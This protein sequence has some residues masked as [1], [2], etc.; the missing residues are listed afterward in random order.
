MSDHKPAV[1]AVSYGAPTKTIEPRFDARVS[2]QEFGPHRPNATYTW[3]VE[4]AGVRYT[5][6]G[7]RLIEEGDDL[8]FSSAQCETVRIEDMAIGDEKVSHE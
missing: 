8:I 6:S 5:F 2:K 1:D 4:R 7:C 3:Q